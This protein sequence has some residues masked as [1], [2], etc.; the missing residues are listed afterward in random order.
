M[1]HMHRRQV[2]FAAAAAA[3]AAGTAGLALSARA[4]GATA[5]GEVIKVDKAG[6]RITIKHGGV[7]NL[8]MPPMIMVFHVRDAGLLDGLAPGDRVRFEAA[9]IDGRYTITALSKAP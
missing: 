8:D 2:I 1:Q 9:R 5:T 4:Q 7:P 3:L 6:S